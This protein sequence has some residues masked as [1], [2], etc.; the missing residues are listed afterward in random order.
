MSE[1]ESGLEKFNQG[2]V[3]PRDRDR[4]GEVERWYTGHGSRIARPTLWV[5]NARNRSDRE[6]EKETVTAACALP[7]LIMGS[8]SHRMDGPS[9]PTAAGRSRPSPVKFEIVDAPSAAVGGVGG[10]DPWQHPCCSP[11][12][13]GRIDGMV[14]DRLQRS[15]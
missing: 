8:A 9:S 7:R 3:I 1:F 14:S 4:A 11:E 12:N 2:R 5:T 6:G 15:A 10:G 13:A